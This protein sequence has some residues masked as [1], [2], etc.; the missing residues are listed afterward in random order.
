MSKVSKSC[1]YFPG[2]ASRFRHRASLYRSTVTS[3][4]VTLSVP[5]QM[6][7]HST[8]LFV[9][10]SSSARLNGLLPTVGLGVCV[11]WLFEL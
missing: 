8:T 11:T 9:A 10:V 5:S 2:P 7:S 6:N 3:W 1:D 4:L